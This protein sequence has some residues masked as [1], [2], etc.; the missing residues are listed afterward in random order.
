MSRRREEEPVDPSRRRWFGRLL[1]EAAE[2]VTRAVERRLPARRR[3]PGAIAEP[4]FLAGCTRCKAC[5]EACP[6]HA[7][8]TLADHVGL[9]AGTPVMVPEQRACQMC[10]GFPCAVAC[11][12]KVLIPPKASV[13]RLGVAEIVTE[14]CLPYRGPECGACAGLCPPGAPALT[15]RL[16][17]PAIEPSVCVGCGRCI[18]ACPVTPHAIALR[19]LDSETDHG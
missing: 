6:H 9:G 13:W 15:L 10:D 16:G 5:V 12:E 3:P 14:R 4:L 18:A 17:R 19:P 2:V 7:I 8:F 1:P 11:P